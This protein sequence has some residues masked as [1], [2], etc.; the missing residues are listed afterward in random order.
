MLLYNR[1]SKPLISKKQR[2]FV[3]TLLEAGKFKNVVPGFGNELLTVSIHCKMLEG[4]EIVRPREAEGLNSLLKN[5]SSLSM[6]T[7]EDK[8]LRF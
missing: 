7:H 4:Q 8:I 5:I 6:I 1:I 3:L 2:D